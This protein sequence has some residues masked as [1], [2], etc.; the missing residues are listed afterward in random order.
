MPPDPARVAETRAWLHK[1]AEDLRAGSHQLLAEPPLC[2]DAAFHAQQACE[3]AAKAF[4]AWHDV[5]FGKTHNLVELGHAC[6]GISADLEPVLRSA[7]PLT[8]YAW[9]FRYPGD[10]E[11]PTLE[12]VDQ[13]LLVA[14]EVLEAILAGLPE[15]ARP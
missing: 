12:E 1:A 11:E 8:E 6:A 2:A 4:L 15:D 10:P 14:R 9:R 3:K 5:P 7:A 13:A